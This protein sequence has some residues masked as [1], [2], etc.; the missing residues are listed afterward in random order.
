MYVHTKYT[1]EMHHI[2]YRAVELDFTYMRNHQ[3]FS[4]YSLSPSSSLFLSETRYR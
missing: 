1:D 3:P 4:P 2:S